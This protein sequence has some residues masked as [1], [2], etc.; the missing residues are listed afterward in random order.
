MKLA[1][2]RLRLGAAAILTA[3]G[4]GAVITPGVA[5]AGTPSVSP[6]VE[7]PETNNGGK[8]YAQVT[9]Y[10]YEQFKTEYKYVK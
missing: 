1:G 5:S 2:N 6:S 4:L 8:C 7:H 9:Q 10:K 3:I